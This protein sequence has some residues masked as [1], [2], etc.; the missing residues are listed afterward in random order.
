MREIPILD[1]VFDAVVAIGESDQ[2]AVAEVVGNGCVDAAGFRVGAAVRGCWDAGDR[3]LGEKGNCC[4]ME[5]GNRSEFD[6]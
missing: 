2:L 5:C 3:N 1:V 6:F 4:F